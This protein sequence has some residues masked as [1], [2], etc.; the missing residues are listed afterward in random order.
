MIVRKYNNNNLC[1]LCS[2][3][4]FKHFT[5]TISYNF[6]TNPRKIFI[7][8]LRMRK[9]RREETKKLFLGLSG[10]SQSNEGI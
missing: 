1:Q 4:I 9:L 3:H 7:P 5:W 6:Q 8:I 10:G 2:G